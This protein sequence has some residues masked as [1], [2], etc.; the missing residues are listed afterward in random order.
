MIECSGLELLWW[1]WWILIMITVNTTI[2]LIV[3]FKHRF[4]KQQPV[5]RKQGRPKIELNMQRFAKDCHKL[6]VRQLAKKY[7][8]SLGK[9]HNLMKQVKGNK[10]D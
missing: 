9:A 8:I 5:K 4:K 7:K 3:F 2:N 1:Q 6:T 10:H